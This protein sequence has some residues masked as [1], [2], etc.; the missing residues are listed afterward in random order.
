MSRLAKKPIVM[1]PGVSVVIEPQEKRIQVKGPKGVLDWHY[2]QG[3]ILNQQKGAAGETILKIEP[4]DSLGKALL[5]LS[6]ALIRNMTRGVT[7]GYQKELEIQGVGYKAQA[8]GKDVVLALG[9]SHP[10]TF[11]PP[12]GVTI[13]IG[14]KQTTL[15][16]SGVNK[17]LVGQVASILRSLR[18]PEPYKGKGIRHL[19]EVVRRKA[20]KTAVS[21]GTKK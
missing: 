17:A 10:I 15:V 3:V 9:K 6:Y 20:G 5:G 1:A 12:D 21:A 13:A 8:Q 18:P 14:P 7:E 19:G 11:T 2:P 4:Q 16:I